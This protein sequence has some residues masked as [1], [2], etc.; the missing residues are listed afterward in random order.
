MQS[1][2]NRVRFFFA[3]A[4]FLLYSLSAFSQAPSESR[5]ASS[6][7]GPARGSVS[8]GMQYMV[9]GDTKPPAIMPNS[10]TI[11]YPELALLSGQNGVVE[12]DVMVSETGAVK[13]VTVRKSDDSVF[14]AAAVEGVKRFQFQPAS[15]GGTPV[16]MS[17]M[18]EVKFTTEDQWT[19][20]Y[21]GASADTSEGA[22][23]SWAYVGD[24]H[25]P[26]MDQEA[27]QKNLVYPQ[28]AKVKSWQ[29]T[30]MVRAR[31]SKQGKVLQ[32]ELQ[33]DPNEVLAAAAVEAITKTPFTPGTEGGEPAEMWTMIPVNFS[34]SHGLASKP[35][36]EAP[37]ED[38]KAEGSVAKPTFDQAELERNFNFEGTVSEVTEIKL[39]VMIDEK[40][41]VKQVLVPDDTDVALATA[42]VNAVQN[43][44]F[45]PGM[46]N[47]KAIPVWITV[48]LKVKPRHN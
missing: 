36:D 38:P 31:V 12:L 1:T 25:L 13:D 41:A 43:T 27:F 17:V 6:G 9:D 14:T 4:A 21:D 34:M 44:G 11:D 24:A 22:S 19:A 48:E 28:E 7:Q 37:K 3:T 32:T 15:S 33:G 40:G 23:D 42:A 29:G 16:E 10:P 46:Q 45:T 8:I 20:V 26:E 2:M 47:G 18:M 35:S 30:V 5:G 39:R